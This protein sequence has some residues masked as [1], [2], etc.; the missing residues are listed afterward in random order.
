MLAGESFGAARPSADF[1]CGD[2]RAQT[3]DTQLCPRP[4]LLWVEKLSTQETSQ[5]R[6]F[7][8]AVETWG[9]AEI[10]G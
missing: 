6:T 9:Q 5:K 1:H 3:E 2:F 4:V 7:F 8:S 10:H